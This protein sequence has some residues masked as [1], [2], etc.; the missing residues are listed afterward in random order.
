MPATKP[1]DRRDDL[2]GCVNRIYLVSCTKSKLA[3]PA[4]A[5]DLYSKS[6]WF[7]KAR[8]YVER[9]GQPWFVLSAKYGLVHPDDVIERY[10][11]TLSKNFPAEQ[12][13]LWALS[14]LSQ[15]EPHL[16]G[17]NCITFLAGQPYREYLGRFL[18]D[19]GL[20]VCAPM[21]HIPWGG[22]Q[23]WLDEQLRMLCRDNNA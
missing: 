1:T 22:Q 6:S 23:P 16:R 2:A 15:L 17:V 18:R 14:V 9:I 10:E 21:E 4:P 11:L 19:R 12:R 7:R 13:R 8:A 20:V 3:G 5:R